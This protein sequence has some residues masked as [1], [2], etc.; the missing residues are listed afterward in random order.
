VD[1]ALLRNEVVPQRTDPLYVHKVLRNE[2]V[3]LLL[4]LFPRCRADMLLVALGFK[5]AVLVR[6]VGLCILADCQHHSLATHGIQ[7]QVMLT[8]LKAEPRDHSA[9][10]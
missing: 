10:K 4:L 7:G 8:N 3:F 1:E 5:Q 9:D 2:H 6:M